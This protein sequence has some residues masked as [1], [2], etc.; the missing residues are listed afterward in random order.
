MTDKV[1]LTIDLTPEEN[2]QVE[3]AAHQQG[4]KTPAE[5]VHA[6]VA[7]AIKPL[8]ARDLLKMRPEACQQILR[9]MAADA[10]ADYRQDSSLTDFEAFG[11]D[12]LYDETPLRWQ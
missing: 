9:A 10:E 6:L 12:D 11:E 1:V 3:Q 4:Y 8:T 2:Q 5:Y 7:D